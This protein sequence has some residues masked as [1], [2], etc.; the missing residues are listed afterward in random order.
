M[1]MGEELYCEYCPKVA[2]YIRS[3]VDNPQDAEDLTSTVFEKVYA[4]WDTFDPGKASVST[5]I[6]TIT[7]NTVTDYF[8]TRRETVAFED[9]MDP[10]C[11][12]SNSDLLD[13]LADAL[14]DLPERERDL[15]L[16]HYYR[17]MTLKDIAKKMGMS[18]INIK[19][20]H[21]KALTGLRYRIGGW[22][23]GKQ[24]NAGTER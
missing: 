12:E 14:L 8:R 23:D 16:F 17:G 4:R 7:R 1:M 2:S 13:A 9:W 18:Y 10:P 22:N 20:I 5:W 21:K 15:I 24:E 6:Y 19:V 3:K 11:V